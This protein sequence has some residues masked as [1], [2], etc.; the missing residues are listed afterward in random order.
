[1]AKTITSAKV[2]NIGNSF[3]KQMGYT[4]Y[5]GLSA[6]VIKPYTAMATVQ[7]LERPIEIDVHKEDLIPTE[8]K[9]LR[10]LIVDR[11]NMMY[12]FCSMSECDYLKRLYGMRMTLLF[13]DACFIDRQIE[14]LHLPKAHQSMAHYDYH[15]DRDKIPDMYYP[16][17]LTR[18]NLDDFSPDGNLRVDDLLQQSK[19]AA[20]LHQDYYGDFNPDDYANDFPTD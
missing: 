17:L 6:V 18:E 11:K 7:V 9:Q 19:A 16:G 4:D 13:F 10:G 5:V 2:V 3:A 1:M 8:T 12:I 14:N 20:K 15:Q